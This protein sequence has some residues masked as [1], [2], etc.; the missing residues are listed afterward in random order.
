MP[1]IEGTIKE[2]YLSLDGT[3]L[4]FIVVVNGQVQT[5]RQEFTVPEGVNPY[6]YLQDSLDKINGYRISESG[7]HVP[8]EGW[9]PRKIKIVSDKQPEKKS[10][11]EVSIEDFNI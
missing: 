1:E 10:S 5:L 3:C 4:Y 2:A 9:T 11:K 8:I 6:H 7:E